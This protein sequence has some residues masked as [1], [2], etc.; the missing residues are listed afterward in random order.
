MAYISCTGGA[1]APEPEVLL[2]A[3]N[4]K[5]PI[6][7]LQKAYDISSL[8]QST[9]SVSRATDGDMCREEEATK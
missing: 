6:G 3:K 1:L 8:M 5:I 4:P 7:F 2:A 9:L